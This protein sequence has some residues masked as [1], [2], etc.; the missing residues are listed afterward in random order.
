MKNYKDYPSVSLGYSDIA[1]LIVDSPAKLSWLKFGG[2]N[3]YYAYLVDEEAEIGDHYSLEFEAEY[4]IQIY[5]DR[6]LTFKVYADQIK[7]YR[8]GNYGCIIQTIGRKEY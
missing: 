6:G 3:E 8:A 7:V 4:W 5:D 2:D 1:R